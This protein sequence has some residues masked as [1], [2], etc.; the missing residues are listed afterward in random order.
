MPLPIDYIPLI[1]YS[2]V[3]CQTILSLGPINSL[4]FVIL[5]YLNRFL[6]IDYILAE[7]LDRTAEFQLNSFGICSC[8][9]LICLSSAV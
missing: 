2:N 8:K 1:Y 3:S 7:R 6:L 9:F 4:L 5:K